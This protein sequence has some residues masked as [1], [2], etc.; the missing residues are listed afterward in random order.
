MCNAGKLLNTSE[1]RKQSSQEDYE[2]KR[3]HSKGKKA[4]I[5]E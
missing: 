2:G 3:G 1:E 4:L 5:R